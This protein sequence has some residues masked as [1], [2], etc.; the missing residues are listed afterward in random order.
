MKAYKV[1]SFHMKNLLRVEFEIGK[2]RELDFTHY[3][4][5]LL[6]YGCAWAGLQMFQVSGLNEDDKSVNM[7]NKK[8]L[9]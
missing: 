4:E 6:S 2:E 9:A 3:S 8:G 1:R 5:M 7:H